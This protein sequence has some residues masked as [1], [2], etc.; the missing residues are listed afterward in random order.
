[1]GKKKDATNIGTDFS[2]KS[3]LKKRLTAKEIHNF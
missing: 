1:M 2:K 3:M